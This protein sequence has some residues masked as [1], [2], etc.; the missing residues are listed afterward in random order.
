MTTGFDRVVECATRVRQERNPVAEKEY[1]FVGFVL[2][3]FDGQTCAGYSDCTQMCRALQRDTMTEHG[4]A[5]TSVILALALAENMMARI[6]KINRNFGDDAVLVV[7]RTAPETEASFA[8]H[9]PG[10]AELEILD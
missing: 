7:F 1:G 8:V 4:D 10:V 6:K 9:T 3:A 2:I 5:D